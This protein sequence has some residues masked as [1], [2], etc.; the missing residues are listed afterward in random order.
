MI[1]GESAHR[2][3][4][5]VAVV[6]VRK[7]IR[8]EP[9]GADIGEVA[10]LLRRRQLPAPGIFQRAAGAVGAGRPGPFGLGGQPIAGA[11]PGVDPHHLILADYIERLKTLPL[12]EPVAVAGRLPPTHPH[13][14][15]LLIVEGGAA[16]GA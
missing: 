11:A 8:K 5:E 1:G 16:G 7:N 13:H 15:L 6:V 3:G 12:A 9:T 14:R 10:G 4:D 2:G